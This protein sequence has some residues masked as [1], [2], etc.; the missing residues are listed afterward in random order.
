MGTS[1]Y[2]AATDGTKGFVKRCIK[3]VSMSTLSPESIQV[4]SRVFQKSTFSNV[5]VTCPKFAFDEKISALKYFLRN[6]FINLAQI[7]T[8]THTH[9]QNAF[10]KYYL[11]RTVC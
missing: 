10:L 11:Y 7:H 2:Y 9:K 4:H 3:F 6:E 5:A 8:H 1:A